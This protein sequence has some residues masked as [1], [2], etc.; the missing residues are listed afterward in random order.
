MEFLYIFLIFKLFVLLTVFQIKHFLADYPLQSNYMLG[1]FKPGWDF[2]KPLLAHVGVHMAFTF[3]ILL[4]FCPWLL[5]CQIVGLTLLDGVIHFIMDRIKAS[6]NY[7]GR[8]KP[9][10]KDEYQAALWLAASSDKDAREKANKLITGNK[11]FWLSLGFDQFVHHLT[12]YLIVFIA[13]IIY[14]FG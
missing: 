14:L 11:Y 10:N 1:K 9:L 3:V 12:H 8:F 2:V 5:W 7:L 4:V 6:P 13:I